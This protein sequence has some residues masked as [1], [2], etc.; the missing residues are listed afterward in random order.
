[1]DF[2]VI[3][4]FVFKKEDQPDFEDLEKWEEEFVLD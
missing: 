1:M 2:L 3:E 4:N